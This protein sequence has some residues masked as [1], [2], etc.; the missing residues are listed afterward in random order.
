MGK[1]IWVTF[2]MSKLYKPQSIQKQ[3]KKLEIGIS[4]FNHNK[5][6]T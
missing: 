4:T 6:V 1:S 5:P 2:S 3:A